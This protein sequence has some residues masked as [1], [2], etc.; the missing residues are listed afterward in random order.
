MLSQSAK[1]KAKHHKHY[2]ERVSLR[3]KEPNAAIRNYKYTPPYTTPLGLTTAHTERDTLRDTKDIRDTSVEENSINS[4][5][6]STSSASNY[7]IKIYNRLEGRWENHPPD[8]IHQRKKHEDF[9]K[10][11]AKRLSLEP[12][13]SHT[14][15]DFERGYFLQY[16]RLRVYTH[17]TD[18]SFT[19]SK[20][21]STSTD[22]TSSYYDSSV[23]AEK[24]NSEYT[25]YLWESS[26]P[27][28]WPDSEQTSPPIELE[29][30]SDGDF[31][32]P[33]H[34]Q[35]KRLTPSHFTTNDYST[36]NEYYYSNLPACF[37]SLPDP[38][39]GLYNEDYL[40]Y[41]N[42]IDYGIHPYTRRS[43][44]Y[45]PHTTE[46]TQV[47][48][49]SPSSSLHSTEHR[50][51]VD[52]D[53]YH[54]RLGRRIYASNHPSDSDN[55]YF[56]C[57]HYEEE[58]PSTYIRKTPT[59]EFP[60]TTSTTQPAQHTPESRITTTST[61]RITSTDTGINPLP[62]LR[63]RQYLPLAAARKSLL[64][65]TTIERHVIKTPCF[66]HPGR[67]K[68]AHLRA[69][70]CISFKTTSARTTV[71][72]TKDTT[73]PS[74]YVLTGKRKRKR[75]YKRDHGNDTPSSDSSSD[76]S[77]PPAPKRDPDA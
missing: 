15:D 75:N 52:E 26:N 76:K 55:E 53:E 63:N 64:D 45:I 23:T 25:P 54:A 30:D 5:S 14:T 43:G 27:N 68:T 51:Q 31:P 61:T 38:D 34:K 62:T 42:D 33:E 37:D 66:S 32:P 56:H 1:A 22:N 35:T 40:R 69:T 60:L 47:H 71:A 16:H 49:T 70:K 48:P 44:L 74:T 18:S 13:Q 20:I 11:E 3:L 57:E 7:T 4:N 46:N 24:L 59:N 29:F 67:F 9:I 8:H 41:I 73:T 72:T 6:T 2:Y 39:T 17:D 19:S 50:S 21:Y 58:V 28:Y 36:Q 65:P 77:T 10:E 12:H